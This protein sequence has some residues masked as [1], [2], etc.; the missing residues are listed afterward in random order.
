MLLN[1]QEQDEESMG[2]CHLIKS[3]KKEKNCCENDKRIIII[4]I[5][6]KLYSTNSIL[7]LVVA[8]LCN[9]AI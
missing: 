5:T 1:N 3:H 4:I 2:L 7:V 8:Y 6:D 9:S